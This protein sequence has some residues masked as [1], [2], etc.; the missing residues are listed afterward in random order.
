MAVA[1]KN[2]PDAGPSVL[3]R[4]AVVSLLGTA[5]VLGSLGILFGLLPYLWEK[6]FPGYSWAGGLLL[7][8]VMVVAA[9]G[10]TALGRR[11][12]GEKAPTGVRAGIFMGLLVFLIVLL[13]TRWISMWL[14][15]WVYDGGMF[16][17]NGATTGAALTGVA[18]LVLLFLAVRWFLRP[19]FERFLVGLEEQGWFTARGYKPLQGIKVRRGTIFGIL[20]IAGAGVYTLINHGTLNRGPLD[21]DLLIPFSAKAVISDPGDAVAALKARDPN[22]NPGQPISVDR[23]ALRDIV[24]AVNPATHVR[25]YLPGASDYKIGQIVSK[26]EFNK[27]AESLKAQGLDP[28]TKREPTLPSWSLAY[29]T[30][31][32]LPRVTLTIPLLLSF[33]SLWLAWRIVNVPAFA[34]FLIATEAELNKVSWTTQRRLVQDTIVVLVTVVLLAVFLFLMDQGWRVILSWK[35]IGVLQISD[36]QQRDSNKSSEDKPW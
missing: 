5:Y 26:D 17:A 19:K 9:V 30:L 12:L 36:E 8:C 21:W 22:Y 24:A 23:E 20:I 13:L 3:D 29:W 2:P 11:L 10:L 33:L 28:P 6:A 15:Y 1:V 32:I 16:G 4:M 31:P 18:G 27:T 35:P 34:D 14:E 25:I 7:A